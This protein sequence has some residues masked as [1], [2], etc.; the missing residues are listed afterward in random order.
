MNENAIITTY[1]VIDEM[2]KAAGHDSHK[3][4]K[5][6]DAEILWLG[7]MAAAYFQNHHERTIG[8]IQRMGY[9]SGQISVSRFNRRL[10]R[11]GAWLEYVVRGLGEMLTGG[12]IYI[13]DSLP[14]PVCK[15]VRAARC[16]KVRGKAYCGYCAA[17]REKYFGWKLHLI[18]T[19][20][21]LLITFELS[22]AALHDL[23]PLHELAFLLP[24]GAFLLGDKGYISQ[25]DEDTLLAQT[26]VQLVPQHRQNMTPNTFLEQAYLRW[27]R[28]AI[29]TVNS[30][31]EKMGIQRLH[32]R[33]N[34]GFELKV[35]ASLWLFF[36]F[37]LTSNQGS[38]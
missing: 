3:L 34:A 35:L 28:K 37:K 11:L 13:I 7:V 20:D 30:R 2:L 29:E 6:S 23:T 4:A 10:H 33:T 38:T 22:P 5:V 24:T 25:A 21:G 36:A 31:L 27:H 26:Q 9:L 18:C 16:R 14:L 17:K 19:P 15:R 32:A 8:V 12:E 1:V